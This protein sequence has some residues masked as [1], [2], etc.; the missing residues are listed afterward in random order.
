MT[1]TSHNYVVSF[2]KLITYFCSTAAFGRPGDHLK[3]LYCYTQIF[4]ILLKWLRTLY[5]PPTLYLLGTTRGLRPRSLQLIHIIISHK[6]LNIYVSQLGIIYTISW[7]KRQNYYVS[8]LLII[9]IILWTREELKWDA[10]R[11]KF[12][13]FW[14]IFFKMKLYVSS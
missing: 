3:T 8:Q 2:N 14:A 1:L 5:I 9:H 6:H 11:P 7:H 10:K 13:S 4:I 12:I